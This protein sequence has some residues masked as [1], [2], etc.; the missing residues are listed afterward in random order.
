MYVIRG[1]FEVPLRYRLKQLI[2]G[3]GRFGELR[4][5][6]ECVDSGNCKSAPHSG[7]RRLSPQPCGRYL[8]LKR[9]VDGVTGDM[10][11]SHLFGPHF[12]P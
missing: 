3:L 4:C 6:A 10:K 7:I 12:D 11:L 9:E 1:A 8:S 5:S 2:P